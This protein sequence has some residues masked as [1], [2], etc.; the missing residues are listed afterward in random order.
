MAWFNPAGGLRYHA[1][2]LLGRA[3]WAPF[4]ASLGSWLSELALS[5]DRALLVGP[6]AGY[7]IPD[8]FLQRFADLTLLEPDP[9]AGFLLARRARA[10]GVPEVRVVRTDELLQPLLHGGAGL[11]ERLERDAKCSVIFCNVLGQT[12]F[13]LEDPAFSRFKAAFVERVLPRLA[14]RSWLS[15]HDRV[16][17]SLAPAFSGVLRVPERLTDAALRESFQPPR[18]S[19]AQV[20]ELLDHESSGFFPALR[21]HVYFTWPIDRERYHVIEGVCSTP[22]ESGRATPAS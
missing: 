12:R 13:L 6:S 7:C 9:L 21:P 20:I 5:S 1:R 16:S 10:L 22:D 18:V 2:A 17:G 4:R 8:E 15:F 19:H 14:D 11:V 3:S